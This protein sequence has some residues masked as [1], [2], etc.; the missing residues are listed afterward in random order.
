MSVGFRSASPK[1][2]KVGDCAQNMPGR[3]PLGHHRHSAVILAGKFY[4]LKQNGALIFMGTGS[5]GKVMFG[6]ICLD[7]SVTDMPILHKFSIRCKMALF[8]VRH[9]HSNQLSEKTIHY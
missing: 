6:T 3:S 7:G 9:L 1:F 4:L 8:V 2:L 5:I